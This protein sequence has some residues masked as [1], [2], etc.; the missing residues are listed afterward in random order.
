M[1]AGALEVGSTAEVGSTV[2]IASIVEVRSTVEVLKEGVGVSTGEEVS[3]VVIGVSAALEEV[4]TLEELDVGV[5]TSE[6][7]AT[8][9][10]IDNNVAASDE[11]DELIGDTEIDSENEEAVSDGDMTIELEAELVITSTV[12][13][14]VV[15]LDALVLLDVL[16]S[17]VGVLEVL[18]TM[19]DEISKT[20]GVIRELEEKLML[21]L[22]LFETDELTD[23]TCECVVMEADD[24][25]NAP[26]EDD[27]LLHLPKPSWHPFPQ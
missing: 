11:D 26:E 17:A 15:E 22:A 13:A 16:G 25:V 1:L 2:E 24:V 27:P 10:A 3:S 19:D 23:K 9:V 5:G 8:D 18:S 20:S 12:G 7:L 6:E 4:S 14:S 21:S